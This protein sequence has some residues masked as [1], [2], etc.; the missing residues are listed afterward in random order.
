M[1]E[2]GTKMSETAYEIVVVNRV[3]GVRHGE[4]IRMRFACGQFCTTEIRCGKCNDF[5]GW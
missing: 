2:G 5:I 1:G 4:H 3:V